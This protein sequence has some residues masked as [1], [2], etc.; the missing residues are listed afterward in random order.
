MESG[1]EQPNQP[2]IIRALDNFRAIRVE[3]VII[4]MAVRV[5]EL[6]EGEFEGLKVAS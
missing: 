3:F 1:Y 5:G 6:H 4:E 2:R